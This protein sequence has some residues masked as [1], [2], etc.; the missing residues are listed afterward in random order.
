MAPTRAAGLRR[1]SQIASA[2]PTAIAATAAIALVSARTGVE[3][4]PA[5]FRVMRGRRA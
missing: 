5:A 4:G 2:K 1:Y 3:Q